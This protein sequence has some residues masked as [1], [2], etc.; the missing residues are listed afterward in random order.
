MSFYQEYSQ[1]NQLDFNSFFKEVNSAD[2]ERVLGKERLTKKD[3]L[4]LL[5]P[6]AS[7]YLE[8]MAQ[9]AS[10]LTLQHF[11]RTMLLYLPLYLADYCVNQCL[12][13]GF[14]VKNK[15]ERSKLDL[16]EIEEE[17]KAIAEKGIKHLLILTGESR[18]HSPVSYLKESVLLLKEY[19]PCLSIEVYPL[20]VAEYQELIA[21]GVEGLTIY[22]EVYDQDIYEEV[23]PDGPKSDYLYRLD[24]P[25]RGCQAGMR[26]VNI[27]A[28]LGLGQWREEAFFAGLH[29]KYL[30][31]KY[32]ETEVNLSVPRL[33]PHLG[34]FQPNSIVGDSQLVQILLA[35]RLFLPR[36]GLNLSTRERA[37]L[38]DNLLPLGITKISAESST[39]VGGY[40]EPQEGTNQFDISDDRDVDEI[41]KLLDNKG[42]QTVFKN[43]HRI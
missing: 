25:E 6:A 15:F 32:L 20:E 12:Y 21:A 17:A 8:E 42:Y 35:Y 24:A 29:A 36:A 30:Q 34:N 9:Q 16:T 18:K 38:R 11:G 10:K 43:W 22:Q 23:H 5:S 14:S 27:G 40:A 19:F 7:N 1:F 31:D 28:L 4:T 41:S 39:E 3:F 13:C 2:V 26:Q 33:R 37:E